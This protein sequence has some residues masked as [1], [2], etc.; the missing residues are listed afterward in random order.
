MAVLATD[1][2]GF[3]DISGWELVTCRRVSGPPIRFTG[4]LVARRSL[5]T[6]SGQSLFIDLWQRRKGTLSIAFSRRCGADWSADI[7]NART[8]PHAIQLV[9]D[10]C[11]APPEAPDGP[12][13][14]PDGA[15]TAPQTPVSTGDTAQAL[16]VACRA[17]SE[18]ALF[19]DLAGLVLDD[20]LALDE[21]QALTL[22]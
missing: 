5:R 13:D 16:M 10:L 6:K 12:Q 2:N 22:E 8:L 9:E 15:E 21:A 17:A 7:V 11:A 1:T 18:D 3:A 4:R 14:S 20:W 19:R